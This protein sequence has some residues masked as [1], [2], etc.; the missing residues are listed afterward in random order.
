MTVREFVLRLRRAIAKGHGPRRRGAK[1]RAACPRA[2][3]A[4]C[5]RTPRAPRGE[6]DP[7]DVTLPSSLSG[8]ARSLRRCSHDRS[9]AA[10]ADRAPLE[11]Q[12]VPHTGVESV[13]PRSLTRVPNSAPSMPP[14]EH[15]ARSQ[16][17]YPQLAGAISEDA[18]LGCAAFEVELMHIGRRG[19]RVVVCW[20]ALDRPV[21]HLPHVAIGIP[22]ARD[23]AERLP[24]IPAG[25]PPSAIHHDRR[26][27][28]GDDHE[29]A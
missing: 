12:F 25:Y 9:H 6:C 27:Y 5:A 29:Y 21:L 10:V 20:S 7:S 11:V 14:D 3:E 26:S 24:P 18:S 19:R 15:N 28:S 23:V 8:R 13:L 1:R 4:R 16:R 17:L 22:A 2:P